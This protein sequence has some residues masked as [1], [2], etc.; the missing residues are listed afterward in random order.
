MGDIGALFNGYNAAS[1]KGYLSSGLLGFQELNG[2]TPFTAARVALDV[3]FYYKEE[4]SGRTGDFV[5]T[6]LATSEK[7]YFSDRN[8]L[9]LYD[10][11]RTLNLGKPNEH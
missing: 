7:G 5:I 10:D 9:I 4:K 6:L 2:I 8:D 1:K 3:T 11:E